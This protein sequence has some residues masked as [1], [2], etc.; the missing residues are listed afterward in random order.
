MFVL[1]AYQVVSDWPQSVSIFV[2]I[3]YPL[4]FGAREYSV[5]CVQDCRYLSCLQFMLVSAVSD[6]GCCQDVFEES[7]FLMEV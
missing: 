5:W 6:L 3:V 7:P 4:T 2:S 1:S